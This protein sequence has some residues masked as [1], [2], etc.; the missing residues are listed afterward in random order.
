MRK[1]IALIGLAFITQVT[2]A[3]SHLKYVGVEQKVIKATNK[4]QSSRGL[5]AHQAPPKKVTVLRVQLSK[6]ARVALKNRAGKRQALLPSTK[7]LPSKFQLGMNVT[8]VLDQ[9]YHGSCATFAVIG[10]M[11]ALKGQG[12]YYSE[13]CSLNLGKH[14]SRNGYGYDGW[15]GQDPQI[16]LHRIEEFGLVS[17]KTQ[18]TNGCGGLTEYP[19]YERDSSGEVTLEEYHQMS[20]P[21]YFT[22][23][24]AWN[25]YFGAIDWITK[26]ESMDKILEKTKLSLYRGNRIVIGTLLELTEGIGAYGTFSKDQDS[27]VLTGRLEQAIELFDLEHS[28]WG[29][30]AMIITGFDDNAVAIDREGVAHKGLF[31][32]RNSWGEEAGDNGNYYMSYDYFQAL[33]VELTEIIKVG[34]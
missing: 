17:K 13:L 8:P 20:Q 11:D 2:F 33:A 22:G 26:D 25:G 9:G 6:K 16:I 15:Q 31:T 3:S 24:S 29:G 14:L 1:C 18:K 12:D 23:L 21:L 4:T 10:A 7:N 32:L 5:R 34:K 19:T 27:W 30:H 28:D